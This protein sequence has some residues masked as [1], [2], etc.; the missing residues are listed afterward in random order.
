M[1]CPLLD[2][3]AGALALIQVV[4]GLLLP[5]AARP[6]SGTRPPFERPSVTAGSPAPRLFGPEV[7]RLRA[8]PCSACMLWIAWL[9]RA[10]ALALCLA[11]VAACCARARPLLGDGPGLLRSRLRRLE[12]NRRRRGRAANSQW[13][14][15]CARARSNHQR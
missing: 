12:C 4:T 14:G 2:C 10:R 9:A 1:V 3:W 11:M 5:E 13:P 15:M 7:A 6:L 8:A